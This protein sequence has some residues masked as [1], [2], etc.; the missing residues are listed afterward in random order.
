M[1]ILV[2][3]D[4]CPIGRN[5]KY[6]KEER[7]AELF[8]GFNNIVEDVDY[9]VVNFE[10]PLT[11]SNQKIRKTGPC[12]KTEDINSLK[13]LQ[14]VGFNLLT[15]ANNHIQDYSGQGVLDTINFAKE[16]GFDT[17]GAGK[18]RI[19]A[20]RPFIKLIK[21]IKIGFINIAENEFC[22]ATDVLPGAN[23]FDFI[24]NIKAIKRLKNDV[25]KIIVIYHGGREH[26]QLPTPEQRKRFRFFIENGVDA[27]VAHHTHCISGVEYYLSKPILYSLGNFVFD[28]KK[29]YQSGNWTKGMSV[30]LSLNGKNDDFKIELIP[31][32]QGREENSSLKLLDGTQKEMFFY[33][34]KLLSDIIQDD[35]KF[36]RE[37]ELYLN[38]QES[39]YLPSLY[40][41]NFIVRALFFKKI[42]PV[43]L[44]RSRHNRLILNLMRCEA[45][46]EISQG[47]LNKQK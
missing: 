7:Y 18:N 24:E 41:K 1:K 40:I 19:E 12:I 14:F 10:C 25:D 31:H 23:T 27:I 45:H 20:S 37:W 15:L 28:Y 3:G 43:S 26:Y 42:L 30:I 16:N 22:A 35:N 5:E 21:G 38:T 46:H 8:N 13:A 36:F 29:K 39:F 34:V 2:T 6:L 44:L 47:I 4:Y 33:K 11:L 9:A 17:V 32:L